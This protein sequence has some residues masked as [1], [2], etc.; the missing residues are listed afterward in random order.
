MNE[1]VSIIIPVYNHAHT[2][3]KAL[4][5]VLAQTYRPLEVIIV[6]DGSTDNFKIIAVEI[7]AEKRYAELNIRIINQ[8]NHGAPAARN[9]GFAE[10]K[11]EYVIFFDADT[12]ASTEMI[13]KMKTA[14]LMNPDAAYAYSGFKFGWKVMRPV[15]FS[16]DLL[17]QNNYI[18]VTSLIRKPD[19]PGFDEVIKK[20]QDWD[21][22][23]TLLQKN[24]TGV[25]VPEILYKKIVAGRVGIS[26]WLPSFVYRL[27]WKGQTVNRFEEARQIVLKKHG[28]AP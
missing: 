13:A 14:L 4:D 18:D 22:W 26:R 20:F 17:K 8:E 12:I 6:N 28:F 19:F 5:S 21:L 23:L 27:P 7:S 11:G 10:A 1:L 2:L 15:V 16:G 24:K 25:C 3:P 9:R